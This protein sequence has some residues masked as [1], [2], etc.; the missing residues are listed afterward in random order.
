LKPLT[1]VINQ[2]LATGIFPQKLKLAKVI[3]VYKK[4]EITLLD[5]YRPISL[6]PVLSKVFEKII[7]T[8]IHEHFQNNNLFFS[9][10]Y[11]FREHHSTE[12]AQIELVD[13]IILN[14][15]NGKLPLNIYID[16]SKAFDTIDHNIL[17]HKLKHYG[18]TEK[19]LALLQS[20]LNDRLQ[21]VDFDKV[22]SSSRFITAG[23]PQGSILGPLLFI[24]YINDLNMASNTF[25]FIS[26][27]DDTTLS[28]NLSS[29]PNL[30]EI[31]HDI[32]AELQKVSNWLKL[33]KLSLNAAKTKC[34]IFHTP[35]K[36]VQV[37]SLTIEN[38]SIEF[39]DSFNFLGIIIDKNLSWKAHISCISKKI[40]KVNG[41]LNKLKHYLPE[42]TLKIMYNSLIGSHLNYGVMC[43]GFNHKLI[44]KLQKKSIRIISNSKYNAHT[45]PIFKKLEILTVKDMLYRMMFL[46][47]SLK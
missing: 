40:A 26:Y 33:N 25:N 10:Q 27:A 34:M 14:L 37:P 22:A 45:E 11:G 12:L 35:N 20:Y 19:S 46:S 41:I 8:Q 13:N 36:I 21:Y 23:V 2:A 7:S 6:L 31:S 15:D 5:N 9:K 47:F 28:V 16:L 24:I 17:L 3:P 39:V 18:F 44:D 1:L 42:V 29:N 32:N 4:N 43:W 30:P 38:E